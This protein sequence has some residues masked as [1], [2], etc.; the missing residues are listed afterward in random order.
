MKIFSKLFLASVI[1][2]FLIACSETGGTIIVKNNHP[3]GKS[4]TAYSKFSPIGYA[5]SFKDSYGPLYI[6]EGTAA[7]FDVSTD[8]DYGIVWK[9]SSGDDTYRV[10]SVSKGSTREISIP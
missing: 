4:V 2:F 8:G 7:S 9:K 10:V 3:E 5:F 6:A 1:L